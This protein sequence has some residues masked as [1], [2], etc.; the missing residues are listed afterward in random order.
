MVNGLKGLIFRII[1]FQTGTVGIDI[2]GATE[3]ES[4][5]AHTRTADDYVESAVAVAVSRLEFLLHIVGDSEAILLRL[6]IIDAAEITAGSKRSIIR[7]ISRR[8]EVERDMAELRQ[9][10]E[11]GSQNA[12]AN[13]ARYLLSTIGR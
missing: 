6:F 3:N 4:V 9:M 8:A 7:G 11:V 2:V 13:A 5:A 10:L 12:T 1:D